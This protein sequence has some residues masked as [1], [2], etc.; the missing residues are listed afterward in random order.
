MNIVVYQVEIGP[1]G[2]KI[3]TPL[4]LFSRLVEAR[5]YICNLR[6]DGVKVHG[7]RIH[8]FKVARI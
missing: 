7:K 8:P 6:K 5:D 1:D 4:T 3:E 2:R